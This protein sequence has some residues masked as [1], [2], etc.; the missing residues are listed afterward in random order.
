MREGVALLVAAFAIAGCGRMPVKA[1]DG[2]ARSLDQLSVFRGGATGD[3]MSAHSV[4]EFGSIDG[5]RHAE[6]TYVA[7]VLPGSHRV[8]V[9]QTLRFGAAKR[10][11]FCTFDMETAAGCLYTPIPPS[12]PP[13]SLAGKGDDFRWSV[14]LPVGIE[15]GGGSA[16][17]LRIAARCG[18]AGKLLDERPSR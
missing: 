12:P 16:Y 10:V 15:C 17:M 9:K 14:E 11:Q 6:G 18:S 8:G 1:Y 4:V 2:P 7:S 13:D 3:E 5:V